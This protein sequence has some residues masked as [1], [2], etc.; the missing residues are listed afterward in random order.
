MPTT[1]THR[2][3]AEA[4]Y[5]SGYAMTQREKDIA[6]EFY[7]RGKQSVEAQLAKARGVVE[8]CREALDR[9][10]DLAGD[11]GLYQES[12]YREWGDKALA[13]AAEFL[14]KETV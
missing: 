7:E 8:E 2:E 13:A 3:A 9:W 6:T 12:P 10:N 11:I 4:I 14:G 5:A 1:D